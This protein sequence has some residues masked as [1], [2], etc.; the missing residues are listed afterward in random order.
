MKRQV[1]VVDGK[2]PCNVCKLVLP[3]DQFAVSRA[4]KCG[5]RSEC[6]SCGKVNSRKWRVKN[7]FYAAQYNRAWREDNAEY[8]K[9]YDLARYWSD[10]EAQRARSRAH[11]ATVEG[12]SQ[13]ALYEQQRR[14]RAMGIVNDLTD[15]QWLELV[16]RYGGRC[17]ACGRDDLPL[18]RDHVVP[19]VKGG[20]L[21]LSNVQPLCHP[22]NSSKG[23][24]VIDYRPALEE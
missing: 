10:P 22:C 19:M 15:A 13:R 16:E 11:R 1:V 17:L 8:L 21:T 23:I 2:L 5:Y 7:E 6:R 12:R 9:K 24:K 18:T 3:V 4:R 20:A 14:A